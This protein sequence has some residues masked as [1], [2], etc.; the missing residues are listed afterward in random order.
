MN[1]NDIRKYFYAFIDNELDVEKNIE[2]LAHLDMCYECSQKMEKERLL[3]ERVKETVCMVK[4]PAYL[5][6]KIFESTKRTETRP[7]FF[8]LLKENLL[9]KSRLIP[10]AGIATAMILIICF[11]VIPGNLKKNDALYL[12]ESEFHNYLMENLDPDIRSQSVKS[13]IEYFQNQ[14]GLSVTLPAI[15][16]D[17]QLIGAALPRIKGVQVP[18]IFYMHDDTP[19]A[20]FVVCNS[21]SLP[22][23]KINID[24]SRMRG[25]LKDNMTLYTDTGYCGSCQIIGWKEAGNEYVMMSNLNSDKMMRILKKV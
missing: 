25:V 21:A 2:I 11:L 15:K 22:G 14:T 16:E 9:L 4:T 3:H 23:Y 12:A 8:T 6:N 24:F 1:C 17:I 5:K 18:L 10:L 19:I 7:N 13:I 20:L